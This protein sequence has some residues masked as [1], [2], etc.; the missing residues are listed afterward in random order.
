MGQQQFRRSVGFYTEAVYRI[1]TWQQRPPKACLASECCFIPGGSLEPSDIDYLPNRRL[2]SRGWTHRNLALQ[3]VR[4]NYDRNFDAVLYFADDDNSYDV[5]LFNNYIRNVSR[6]GVWAVGL[7]GGAWVE[8]P[9]VSAKGKVIAWDV[10]FA[11]NRPFATDMAGFAIN[12]KELF[13][14]RNAT[15]NAHCAK[16]YK[17]GPESCFLSQFGFT[18][19]HLEPFGYKE[20][21]KEIL[22]WHTKTSKSKTR[23]PKR[24]YAIE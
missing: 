21:P 11:P 5:R 18:K 6:I 8:A 19:Q 13:R 15:F 4:E 10:M 20:Y 22:V 7:V 2:E 12:T 24:G 1:C 14:A 16:N 23:G 17:Q 9:H 3:Y